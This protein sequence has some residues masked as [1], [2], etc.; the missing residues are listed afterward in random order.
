M[1]VRSNAR[2]FGNIMKNIAKQ[3]KAKTKENVKL[4]CYEMVA[5]AKR[6]TPPHEGEERGRNTVTGNM[7][8]H[9]DS[10]YTIK[11]NDSIK[12]RLFNNVQYASYVE[13]GHRMKKHF[14]PWLYIDGTGTIARHQPAEA[15]KRSKAL[16]WLFNIFFKQKRPDPGEPLFGLVVG[17]KTKYVQPEHIVEKAKKRFFEAYYAL[18]TENINQTNDELERL[19]G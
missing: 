8:R 2:E 3:A 17:T 5:E 7:A 10:S 6:C 14:V 15:N 1:P 13:N 9:W 16:S 19:G 18:Q 11:D 12:V 4:A